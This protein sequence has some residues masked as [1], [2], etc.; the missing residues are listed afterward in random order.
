MNWLIETYVKGKVWSIYPFIPPLF[1]LAMSLFLNRS[2]QRLYDRRLTTFLDNEGL[3]QFKSLFSDLLST[4]ILQVAYL[5]EVPAFVVSVLSAAQGGHPSLLVALALAE[6]V[7]FIVVI[8]D[9][10]MTEVDYLPLTPF[11][12]RRRPAFIAKRGWTQETFYSL[13]LIILNFTILFILVITLP[14]K[15]GP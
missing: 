2:Y 10:F 4:R 5:T 11:P 13:L 3:I 6:L 12:K 15:K 1:S 9:V 7:I 14:D 8:P